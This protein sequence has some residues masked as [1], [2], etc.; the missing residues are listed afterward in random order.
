MEKMYNFECWYVVGKNE[1][2]FNETDK[3]N[4]VA[5]DYDDAKEKFKKKSDKEIHTFFKLEEVDPKKTKAD[6]KEIAAKKVK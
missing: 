3:L 1:K 6:K 4:L 5:K 2:G